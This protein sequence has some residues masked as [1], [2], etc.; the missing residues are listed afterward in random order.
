MQEFTEAVK[1]DDPGFYEK[2]INNLP[3]QRAYLFGTL[4]HKIDKPHAWLESMFVKK[5]I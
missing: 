3:Y 5:K 1:K 2:L 4:K